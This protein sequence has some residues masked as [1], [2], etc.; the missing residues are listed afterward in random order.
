MHFE[1]HLPTWQVLSKSSSQQ[2]IC[3]HLGYDQYD[4]AQEQLEINHAITVFKSAILWNY[5]SLG[6]WYMY[7]RGFNESPQMHLSHYAIP[8]ILINDN[9]VNILLSIIN[10]KQTSD[11]SCSSNARKTLALSCAC[12]T[13]T[14]YLTNSW[15]LFLIYKFTVLKYEQLLDIN[16]KT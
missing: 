16:I 13:Y 12:E 5:L 11:P 8:G 3:N 14:G 4:N 2:I 15:K 9:N 7:N 6:L 10:I 1:S